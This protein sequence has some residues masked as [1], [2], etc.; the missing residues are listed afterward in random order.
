MFQDYIGKDLLANNDKKRIV[1]ERS[2]ILLA[3][4]SEV[5]EEEVCGSRNWNGA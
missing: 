5:C 2:L 1:L 3:I 4:N